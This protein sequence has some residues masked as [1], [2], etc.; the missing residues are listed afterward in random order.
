VALAATV[1]AAVMTMT[2]LGARSGEAQAD[3]ASRALLYLQ[4]QQ[5]ASDGSINSGDVFSSSLYAIGAAAAGYDPTTLSHGGPTVVDFLAAQAATACRPATGSAGRCGA[6]IQAVVAAARDPRA[7]PQAGSDLVTLLDGFRNPASGGF[8]DAGAFSQALAIQALVAAGAPVPSLAVSFVK[9]AQDSD[10]GWNYKDISNDASGSDT[11][12]T[13]MSLMALDAAGD[14]SRDGVALAWLHTQQ[15]GDG[16]FPYQAGAGVASDPDSTAVVLQALIGTGQ[17]PAAP[18]WARTGHTPITA[19]AA[20]QT[21]GGGYPGY[22]GKPDPFTTAQVPTA[23]ERVALPV[24]FS[25]RPFY[26][27][28]S[29]LG[30]PAPTPAPPTATPHVN[31]GVA[32][33]TGVPHTGSAASNPAAL[34]W[35]LVAGG[36]ALI[37]GATVGLRRRRETIRR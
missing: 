27:P 30:G 26:T 12:S 28:G 22:T 36:G 5:S 25:T 20:M 1:A 7:F 13:A 8:G 3:A 11:N 37:G 18:A 17:D 15:D 9:K 6:L 19:L 33:I 34:V 16:G 24:P 32:G 35:G 10:G 4:G 31:A 2:G 29:R 14:H 23:L 21:G